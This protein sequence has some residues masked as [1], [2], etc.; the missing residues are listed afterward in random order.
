MV[1]VAALGVT[2][3]VLGAVLR[4][5]A[6]ELGLLLTLAAGV[7]M[8]GTAAVGLGGAAELMKE[9]TGLS[10]LSEELVEPVVKTVAIS[11]LT[12][13]TAEVCR[14][15]GESGTAAFVETAGTLLALFVALPLIRAVT[16]LMAE[17]L[18]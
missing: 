9:L 12:R 5:S 14:S 16:V 18:G 13:V 3:A 11:I 6:P 2:A 17:I 15:A 1:K 7:W 8:L 10:G 4:K